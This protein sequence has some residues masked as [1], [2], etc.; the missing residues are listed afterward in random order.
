MAALAA[1]G[2]T[3]EY[4]APVC[5]H[6]RMESALDSVWVFHG[7]GARFASGVFATEADGLAWV[8]SHRLTG[9]LTEYPLGVGAYDDAVARG[10]SSRAVSTTAPLGTLLSSHRGERSTSTWSTGTPQTG[11]DLGRLC[12]SGG[13]RRQAA[14]GASLAAEWGGR[15]WRLPQQTAAKHRHR[16]THV[17]EVRSDPRIRSRGRRPRK[18]PQRHNLLWTR[19]RSGARSTG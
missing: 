12:S 4:A 19:G 16:V 15:L 10:L 13:P 11:S 7:E 17:L 2:R 1:E 3:C 18:A 9:I 8:E 6:S 5:K 14:D